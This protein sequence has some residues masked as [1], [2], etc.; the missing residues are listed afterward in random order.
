MMVLPLIET[1]KDPNY[2]FTTDMTNQAISWVKYQQALTPEKPFFMYYAPGATH[3]P[4]HVPKGI[5]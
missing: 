1:P 2:H 4:H 5:D 3:A